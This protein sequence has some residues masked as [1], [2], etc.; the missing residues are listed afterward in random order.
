MNGY[1]EENSLICYFHPK[2]VVIGVC[3]LCL[4]ERLLILASKQ[5]H[6]SSAARSSTRTRAQSSST[7]RK[8]HITLPKIFALGGS[9]LSRLEFRHW[10]SEHSDHDASTSQEA[11]EDSFI[12]IKIG[13]NGVASWENNPVLSSKVPLE[14]CNITRN[15][16]WFTKE[17]KETIK[18][19]ATAKSVVEHGKP[20]ASLRWRKR[21]GHLFQLIRWKRSNK[22]NA[23]HVSSKVE[24]VKVIRKS[25]IRTLTKRKTTME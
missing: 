18:E 25:W 20:R 19:T 17:A 6:L 2:Q 9:L 21:I 15:H 16:T 11:F 22:G 12:S 4:N 23:R 14:N 3:P 24:G 8:P 13:D 10:K 7:H 1:R 5:G